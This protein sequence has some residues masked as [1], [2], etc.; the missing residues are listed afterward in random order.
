M[1]GQGE[2]AAIS[3]SISLQS[4]MY[5]NLDRGYYQELSRIDDWQIQ[6]IIA[7]VIARKGKLEA[8]RERLNVEAYGLKLHTA[9]GFGL[10]PQNIRTNVPDLDR[11]LPIDPSLTLV[12]VATVHD[13]IPFEAEIFLDISIAREE[14]RTLSRLIDRLVQ[15]KV[16]V[17]Y[18][19]S[20]LLSHI[21]IALR[22]AG[23]TVR[24]AD[25]TVLC[26]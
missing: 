9:L 5:F 1:S 12:R 20:G 24:S 14:H 3:G 8:L 15:A 11:N 19:K 4:A 22:E 7:W 26:S 13:E 23:L 17:V 18:V 2:E 16:P 6:S 25:V 10:S 21:A